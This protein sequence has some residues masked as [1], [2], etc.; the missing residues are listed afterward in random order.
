MRRRGSPARYRSKAS[1]A[2]ATAAIPILALSANVMSHQVKEYL[3]A[4]IDF[5]FGW[6][7]R[8]KLV[9]Q[10]FVGSDLNSRMGLSLTSVGAIE[11]VIGE[12]IFV[13]WS[14]DAPTARWLDERQEA[15]AL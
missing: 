9:Q 4:G 1:V 8:G 13:Y 12:P 14:Y 5:D 15:A 2:A 11:N 10:A 6:P 7:M 3:A